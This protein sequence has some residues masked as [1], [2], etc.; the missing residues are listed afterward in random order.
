MGYYYTLFEYQE[1]G[2]WKPHFK[3]YR[4]WELEYE[5]QRLVMPWKI[6]DQDGRLVMRGDGQASVVEA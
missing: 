4:L 6:V 1:A 5:S 2:I 3:A